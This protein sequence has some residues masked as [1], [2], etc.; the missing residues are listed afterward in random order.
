MLQTFRPR[1]VQA[2]RRNVFIH[3]PIITTAKRTYLYDMRGMRVMD[4]SGQSGHVRP[5]VENDL[6]TMCKRTRRL[7][8]YLMWVFF[9]VMSYTIYRGQIRRKVHWQLERWDYEDKYWRDGYWI[10][11]FPEGMCQVTYANGTTAIEPGRSDGKWATWRH[12]FGEGFTMC[13]RSAT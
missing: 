13:T 5:W 12:N 10:K 4:D 7:E 9:L 2:I 1:A 8:Q 3:K 11:E 6:L